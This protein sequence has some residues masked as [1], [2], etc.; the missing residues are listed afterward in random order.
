EHPAVYEVAVV[1]VEVDG[2]NKIKATV[3]R[4]QDRAGENLADELQQWCKSRLQRYQFPHLVDF[5]EELPKTTTG[6][7]QRFKLR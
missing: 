5:V 4:T 6:K 3:V 2:L 1:G 7:I